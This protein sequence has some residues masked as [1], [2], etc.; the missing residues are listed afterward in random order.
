MVR[1]AGVEAGGTSWVVAI[2]EGEPSN[3]VARAQFPTT[4]PEETLGKV[5]AWL[6]A[7]EGGFDALGIASFGPIDPREGS[8]TYG[9][10]TTT[11]KPG[12]KFTDVV[13]ALTRGRP[14]S[15]P[16][17]FDTDV[18]APA[19]NEGA[20]LG[21]SSC[22]YVTV[23]T[24]LGVGLAVHGKAV[25][26]VLHPEVGHISVPRR[27]GDDYEEVK[28]LRCE[29]WCEV[30]S[31]CCS[32]ALAK[33][34]GV[35]PAGLREL[36]DDHPVWDVAAHYLAALCANLVLT[37]S[38]ERIVL[39]G[40]VLLR[41]SLFPKVRAQMVEML[42]GYIQVDSILQPAQLDEYIVAS[43]HG[44]DAGIVGAL[45]LA[46]EAARRRKLGGGASSGGTAAPAAALAPWMLAAAAVA[47]GLGFVAGSAMRKK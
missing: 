7:Q 27:A 17:L 5:S 38:P 41:R 14:A 34:A 36:A 35:A 39:G 11:P 6:D 23:G 16:V 4:T 1:F 44:N 25:H 26:G 32:G 42:N 13:G 12:W 28:N 22:A 8:P 18:N 24:G 19:V 15:L 20:R 40:G 43:P 33:R 46:Q 37:V 21:C 29:G 31:M 2:A 30:E 10:I 3:I 47:A 45:A 9:Q